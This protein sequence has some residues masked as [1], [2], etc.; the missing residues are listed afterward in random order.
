MLSDIALVLPQYVLIVKLEEVVNCW[1]C[2]GVLW[3][4]TLGNICSSPLF[5]SHTVCCSHREDAQCPFPLARESHT[6]PP[7]QG[8]SFQVTHLV[9]PEW[10]S[11]FSILRAVNGGLKP[12]GRAVKSFWQGGELCSQ[13]GGRIR[14]VAAS[15]CHSYSNTRSEPCLSP[16]PSLAA[17]LDI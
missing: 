14:A 10:F 6:H 1:N 3:E 16:T 15:L 13:A 7:A 5:S 17:M 11:L 4:S 8:A 2:W 9:S 12:P